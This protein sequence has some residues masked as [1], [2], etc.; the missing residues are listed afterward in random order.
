[1][2]YRQFRDFVF[3]LINQYSICGEPVTERYNDYADLEARIPNLLGLAMMNIS[4]NGK[5][6]TG[7]LDIDALE[8]AGK[9]RSLSDGY[10]EVTLPDDFQRM[11]GD[12]I[13][14]LHHGRMARVKGYH[15]VAD[16]LVIKT[17]LMRNAIAIEYEKAPR[18]YA[19]I[20]NLEEQDV[21]LDG[22]REQ[23]YA[24]ALFVAAMLVMDDDSFVYANLMNEY[25]AR[26]SAMGSRLSAE[27]MEI[28]HCMGTEYLYL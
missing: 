8:T 28:N 20:L 2:K 7:T 11:T 14:I 3:Q 16:K 27:A 12:G 5:P 24:A 21:E 22:D 9:L 26:V 25:E 23:Q 4:L 15:L 1:M 10:T 13:P 18:D 19:E 17:E 6:I